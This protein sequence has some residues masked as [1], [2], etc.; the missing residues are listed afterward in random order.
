MSSLRAATRRG[1]EVIEQ[2]Y[3]AERALNE[4]VKFDKASF[5]EKL[6]YSK[7]PEATAAREALMEVHRSIFHGDIIYRS[8]HTKKS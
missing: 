6:Q 1:V 4:A 3:D 2:F 7:D 5:E 8:D